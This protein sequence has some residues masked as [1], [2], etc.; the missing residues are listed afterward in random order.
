MKKRSI[1]IFGSTSDSFASKQGRNKKKSEAERQR[2]ADKEALGKA[3]LDKLNPMVIP[4]L[5][6]Q[7]R[8]SG[9]VTHSIDV[10][11]NRP[12]RLSD[13]WINKL[14][15]WVDDV[16]AAAILEE[17]DIEIGQ[18][19]EFG[20]IVVDKIIPPK[21]DSEFPMPAIMCKDERGWKWYM[22]TSKASEFA[23]G[24]QITFRAVPSGHGEGITFL[25]RPTKLKKV[26]IVLEEDND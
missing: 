17:P 5:A 8:P 7:K 4:L 21:M 12:E 9:F 20:P 11:Q 25:R 1:N 19:A 15:K 22:K 26:L 18:R 2:L 23:A 10:I 24:D 6:S 13:N 3:A 16:A 14:N